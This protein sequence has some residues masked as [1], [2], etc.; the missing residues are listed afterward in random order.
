MSPSKALK[1]GST[2][3]SS[4]SSGRRS[5]S[6]LTLAFPLRPGTEDSPAPSPGSG[7]GSGETEAAPAVPERIGPYRL[8]EVLGEGGMGTVYL[9]EQDEPLERRVALKLIRSGRFDRR[10]LRRFEGERQALA[11]MSHPNIAQVYGAGTALASQP[12]IAMELVPG[13]PITE[14]CDR[15]RLSLAWRL[16]LFAAVCD[17]VQHAHQKAILHRDL[18]P[19]NLLVMETEG[20]PVPKIIDFG[21]AKALDAPRPG[22]KLTGDHAVVGTAAYLSPEAIQTVT[23]TGER[24]VDTR[25]DIYAL[26]VVLY[27]LLAGMRPFDG[28]G[29]SIENLRRTLELEV[30]PPSVRVGSRPDAE[31]AELVRRRRLKKTSALRRALRGDLDTIVLKA[32]ARDRSQRY[33]SAADLAADIRRFLAHEPLLAAP[34]TPLYRLRKAVRRHRAAVAAVTLI[35]LTLAGGFVARSLEAR[36]ANREAER[37]SREAQAARQ[38]A[39]FLA[40]LFERSA[41]PA[42]AGDHRELTARQVLDRGARSIQQDLDDQP[43]LKARLMDTIGNVYRGLGAY[44]EAEPLLLESLDLRQRM[45]GPEDPDIAEALV[46]LA[47]LYREKGDADQALPLLQRAVRI[48]EGAGEPLPL[49]RCLLELASAE[50]SLGRTAR[51]EDLLRQ[52]IALREEALGSEDVEIAAALDLLGNVYQDERRFDE[53]ERTHLRALEIKTTS[54]GPAHPHVVQSLDNLADVYTE[55][56]RSAEAE[57]LRRRAAAIEKRRPQD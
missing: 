29:A 47:T 7:A 23:P 33:G 56:G 36:R 12:Y 3:E 32:M 28:G 27:E 52:V 51:A 4:R 39:D 44:A 24:D 35:V 48:Q 14:Y 43:L 20:G 37:A 26:G 5:D 55:Q 45:L 53:A 2:S 46:S 49:A 30:P 11:R 9:A 38:V 21:L 54:L 25:A 19:S 40:G 41:G 50:R 57:A 8:L 6:S 10:L 18:K 16:E 31:Q 15:H 1:D 17:G 42:G 22:K 34:P 13:L